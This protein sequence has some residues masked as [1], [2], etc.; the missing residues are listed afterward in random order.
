MILSR[1]LISNHIQWHS[2]KF[3][4]CTYL[5][6]C[7]WW[8]TFLVHQISF[9][10]CW[11]SASYI[12]FLRRP[13]AVILFVGKRSLRHP[14]AVLTSTHQYPIYWDATFFDSIPLGFGSLFIVLQLRADD[15]FI[16]LFPARLV[17]CGVARK[18]SRSIQSSRPMEPPCG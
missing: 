5:L 14:I 13:P 9:I 12:A 18:R 8:L 16:N 1:D 2:T 3:T 6:P 10:Y 15:V 7:S 4:N 17:A 11:E